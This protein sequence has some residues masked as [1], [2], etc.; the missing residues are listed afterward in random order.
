M[1]WISSSGGPLFVLPERA[2]GSW[3]GS[4]GLDGDDTVD[5]DD[6]HYWRLCSSLTGDVWVWP[7][8]GVEGLA[9]DE[10]RSPVTFLPEAGVFVQDRSSLVVTDAVIGSA[11]VAELDW[12]DV[13]RW[14]CVGACLMFDA[15]A[16]GPRLSGEDVLAINVEPA[17]YMVST[18]P[19]FASTSHRFPDLLLTRLS[20]LQSV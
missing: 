14:R 4:F 6:T 10:G 18:A 1:R 2:I 5:E 17:E 12:R 13:G 15:V 7:T 19:W 16:Y 3:C 11:V 9:F 20:K 8:E